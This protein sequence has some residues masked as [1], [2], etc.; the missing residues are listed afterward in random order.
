MGE[1][2]SE[3]WYTVARCMRFPSPPQLF[4]QVYVS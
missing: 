1:E 4:F 2:A 3:G